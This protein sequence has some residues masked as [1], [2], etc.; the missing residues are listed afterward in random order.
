MA[1]GTGAAGIFMIITELSADNWKR[2]RMVRLAALKE[3]PGAFITSRR[4]ER[5][6]PPR[7]WKSSFDRVRW[8]VVMAGG[9]DVG[10]AGIALPDAG[11]PSYCRY[12]E[13]VWVKPAYRRRGGLRMLLSHIEN[14]MRE[15]EV[16][17][18]RLWVLDTN[19][20][21]LLPYGRLGFH[22]VAPEVIQATLKR[23]GGPQRAES[24]FVNEL[25]LAKQLRGPLPA[26]PAT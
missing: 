26:S 8:L 5:K 19:L 17:E 21:A 14:R 2:L 1:C 11:S 18:L 22:V 15:V 10:L 24:A 3:S 6:R 16:T 25:M 7:H 9:E 23:R 13:S 12:L 20:R 4:I